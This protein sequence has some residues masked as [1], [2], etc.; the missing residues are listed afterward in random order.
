MGKEGPCEAGLVRRRDGR[1]FVI[2][3]TGS[4]GYLGTAWSSNEGKAWTPP[5]L[6]L[7]KG[8]EP[9][10]RLLSNGVLACS[11]GRPGRS[12]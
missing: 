1:L 5:S 6:I 12:P 4:D 2:Y 9:R 11:T 3:R 8:V 10:V 7:F